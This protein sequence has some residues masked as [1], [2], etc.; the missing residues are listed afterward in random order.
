MQS[1]CRGPVPAGNGLLYIASPVNLLP[2]RK[3]FSAACILCSKWIHVQD[4][5]AKA[6]PCHHCP[7]K[8]GSL[9][10]RKSCF[11]TRSSRLVLEPRQKKMSVLRT[12]LVS[13]FSPVQ[14]YFF[15]LSPV[16]WF[17]HFDDD[18]YVN[19]LTLVKTLQSF[20]PHEDVY[21]GKPSLLKAMEVI[22]R[23]LIFTAKCY[24]LKDFVINNSSWTI[25]LWHVK[26]ASCDFYRRFWFWAH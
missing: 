15:L 10:P 9:E 8:E 4:I 7:L 6:A 13:N 3:L 25:I 2:L 19:V 22:F 1:K 26:F 18:N 11:G 12:F 23:T 21:L 17:C 24:Q 16:R 5:Y 14:T 20:N